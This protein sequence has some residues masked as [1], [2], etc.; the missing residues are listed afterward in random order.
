MSNYTTTFDTARRTA[1]LVSTAADHCRIVVDY[2]RNRI[3]LHY[4][5]NVERLDA[6]SVLAKDFDAMC[7][8]FFDDAE[9]FFGGRAQ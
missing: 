4:A 3:Y 2:D 8:R 5:G 9:R 6:D 7:R 1:Y